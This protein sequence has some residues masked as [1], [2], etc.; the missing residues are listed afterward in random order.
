VPDEPPTARADVGRDGGWE[1][2]ADAWITAVADD[3]SRKMLDP[4]MLRLCGD[5]RG[6]KM[7][8]VGCGEGRFSRLLADRGALSVGIDPT[9][10]LLR[11]ARDRGSMSPA[12]AVAEALPFA[13]SSFDLAVTYI[14]LV[15]IEHYRE[16]IAEM[17]RV[18]RPGA[19]LAAAN[20]GFVSAS[21][22]PNGSW[23]RDE[24]GTRLYVP[25]DNYATERSVVYEWAGLR[26]RN[27]H[28]PLGAYMSAY[29]A[30][31]LILREFLEPVPPERFRDV[32]EFN[33]AFRVPWLTVMLWEKP[34][35]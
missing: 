7:I 25:I 16:A 35:V 14:T 31:G 23:H 26:L 1:A 12:R 8:D 3:P 13:P 30:V 33:G 24:D 27:Y 4:I 21:A 2:S 18:L 11:A 22:A 19:R 15:D 6:R 28:R 10:T 5:V 17:A 32:P 29:L 20:I 34:V 9:E